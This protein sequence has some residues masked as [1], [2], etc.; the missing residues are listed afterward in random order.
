MRAFYGN[1]YVP[2][3]LPSNFSVDDIK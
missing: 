3:L 1:A 2:S